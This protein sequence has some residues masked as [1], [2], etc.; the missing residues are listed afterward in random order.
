[1][2]RARNEPW[3]GQEAKLARWRR[4]RNHARGNGL[5]PFRERL[6]AAAGYKVNGTGIQDFNASAWRGVCRV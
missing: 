1:M 5:P 4:E 2:P 6:V 3:S